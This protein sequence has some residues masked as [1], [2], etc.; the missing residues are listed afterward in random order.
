[1]AYI[2]FIF[3]TFNVIKNYIQLYWTNEKYLKRQRMLYFQ[4]LE[5]LAL[6]QVQ[7]EQELEKVQQER[8]V[9][10]ARLLSYIYNGII[11]CHIWQICKVGNPPTY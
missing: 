4:L 7:L 8:D 5:D 11:F 2:I 1:M 6:Q 9:N 3:T 10:R